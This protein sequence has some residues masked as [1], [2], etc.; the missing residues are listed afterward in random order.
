MNSASSSFLLFLFFT[1]LLLGVSAAKRDRA[2]ANSV[3][4]RARG[5]A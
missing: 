3:P 5:E 2:S 4:A 1:D